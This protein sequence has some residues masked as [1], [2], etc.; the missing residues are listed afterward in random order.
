MPMDPLSI[1][2]IEEKIAS[3]FKAIK[4]IIQNEGVQDPEILGEIEIAMDSF[5]QCLGESTGVKH[6]N[7]V[8]EQVKEVGTPPQSRDRNSSI[9]ALFSSISDISQDSPPRTDPSEEADGQNGR[10]LYDS[11]P[12]A[13]VDS[14]HF[15]GEQK[16]YRLALI[17]DKMQEY[18]ESL[19]LVVHDLFDVNSKK[20]EKRGRDEIINAESIIFYRETI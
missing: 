12:A 13:S 7:R 10:G 6:K 19:Q 16:G 1:K 14:A 4:K 5:D 2:E 8:I 17:S 15:T 11:Q 9:S 18:V 20:K 3:D